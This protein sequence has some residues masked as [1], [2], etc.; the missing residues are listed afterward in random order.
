MTRLFLD[1]NIVVDVL[2]R[3]TSEQLTTRWLHSS[4]ILKMQ[5]N[6][7]QQSKPRPISSLHVMERILLPQNFL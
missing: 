5:C 7:I 4:R 3:L 2:Q 6:I 1:T